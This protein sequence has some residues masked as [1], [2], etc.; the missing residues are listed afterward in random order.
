[1]D[2]EFSSRH[3]GQKTSPRKRCGRASGVPGFGGIHARSALWQGSTPASWR[4]CSR[5]SRAQG[6]A[7]LR[8]TIS[9]GT[10]S[11]CA[12]SWNW[13]VVEE[14]DQQAVHLFG[15]RDASDFAGSSARFWRESP[16]TFRR[17]IETRFRGQPTFQEETKLH[18]SARRTRDRR[19]VHCRPAG[20]GQ[21]PALE[22]GRHNGDHGAGA[23]ARNAFSSVAGGT[24][25]TPPA[26]IDARRAHRVDCARGRP[27][28]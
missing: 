26:R 7:N 6:V 23:G 28:A 12:S 1:M 13:L 25:R 8:S 27:A 22:P 15:A 9:I 4:T 10:P 14:V 20:P 21:R 24:S 2:I 3:R 11:S 18:C 17:A 16:Q 19:A 5:V